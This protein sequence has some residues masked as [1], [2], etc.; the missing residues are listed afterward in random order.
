MRRLFWLTGLIA[1]ALMAAACGGG[2]DDDETTVDA[3]S[4]EGVAQAGLTALFRGDFDTLETLVCAEQAPVITDLRDA[5]VGELL[6]ISET[7]IDTLTYTAET[8]D[9]GAIVRVEGTLTTTILNDT[10][11]AEAVD[12]FPDGLRVIQA[13]GDWLIC[14]A[15]ALQGAA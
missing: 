4:P 15:A 1:L 13:D 3:N 6:A 12:L 2:G 9:D 14:D 11:E 10:E 7:D 5:G 8:D